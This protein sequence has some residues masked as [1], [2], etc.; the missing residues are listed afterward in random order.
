MEAAALKATSDHGECCCAVH[1]S[2]AHSCAFEQSW[3]ARCPSGCHHRSHKGGRKSHVSGLLVSADK[4][5]FRHCRFLK[6]LRRKRTRTD[7]RWS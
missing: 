1:D 7:V 4:S 3:R 2:G 5:P 6:T